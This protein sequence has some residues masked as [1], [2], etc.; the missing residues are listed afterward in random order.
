MAAANRPRS[1]A[2]RP[3]P[4][5]SNTPLIVVVV[6]SMLANVGL[7]VMWYLSQEKITTAE[8]KAKQEQQAAAKAK[9]ERDTFENYFLVMLRSFIGDDKVSEAEVETAKS[10]HG[11]AQNLPAWAWYSSLLKQITGDPSAEEKAQQVGLIG[12]FDMTK[13][14]PASSLA[15]RVKNQEEQLAA[16][17]KDLKNRDDQLA[18][19]KKDFEDWKKEYNPQVIET[20]I[21]DE[22]RRSDAKL[23]EVTKLKD[24]VIKNLENKL[25]LVTKDVE[26]MLAD[27]KTAAEAELKKVRADYDQLLAEK[28]NELKELI[29]KIRS[30]ERVSLDQPRGKIVRVEPGG[31]KVYINLG[32]QQRLTPQTTFA[33]H[34]PGSPQPKARLEVISIVGPS[35]ALCRVKQLA[36]PEGS[37]QGVD[38]S[39]EDYWVSNPAEFWRT[40]TQILE[41][42]LIFNPAWQPNR[43][44]HVGLAGTFDLDG[45]GQ[46]D[47]KT[48]IQILQNMGVEVDVY[49][50]PADEFKPRGQL[51]YQT[52]YLIIGGVPMPSKL[53]Q[54]DARALAVGKL[55]ESVMAL[56]KDAQSKGVEVVQLA[57][58]LDRMGYSVT[59]MPTAAPAK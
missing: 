50:D 19:V 47:I 28:E 35:L 1:R 18:Q 41:G 56:V 57:K 21:R 29:Q 6:L 46:D 39:S 48:F 15:A 58:F 49:T 4:A 44:V 31:D 55:G 14:R 5:S 25:A 51:T 54:I 34:S 26:K 11:K 45:D 10:I 16:L 9:E 8:G 53:T 3:A 42:D 22:Q 24:D 52:E 38:S 20:K 40:R 12:P 13:W 43:A 37:R 33:V 23:A 27:Q 32:S 30:A 17:R 59:R 36:K 2:P 7:G